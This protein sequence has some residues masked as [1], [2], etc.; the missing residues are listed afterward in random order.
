MVSE[1]IDLIATTTLVAS[2]AIGAV[3]LLRRSLHRL[4][5]PRVVYASWLLVPIALL[6]L[7]LPARTVSVE[8]PVF[9]RARPPAAIAMAGATSL[10]AVPAPAAA[11]GERDVRVLVLAVWLIG[12]ALATGLFGRQQWRFRRRIGRLRPRDDGS[13]ASATRLLGPAVLGLLRP[14]IIVPLDFDHRYDAEQRA[15]IL[16]HEAVHRRRGDL[17]ANAAATALRCIHWF[18]PLVHIAAVRFRAD[19]EL[20]CDAA[21]LARFPESRRRYADAMLKTQLADLGLPVGCAW[22]SSHPMRERIAMLNNPPPGALRLVVG[23]AAL[24]ATTLGSA[25]AVWAAQPPVAES[26]QSRVADAPDA[27]TIDAPRAAASVGGDYRFVLAA[28]V[29]SRPPLHATLHADASRPFAVRLG[30]GEQEILAEFRFHPSGDGPA[31]VD[32]SF[33]Q[34]DQVIGADTV[35]VD[36]SGGVE[37]ALIDL[38]ANEVRVQVAHTALEPAP[39]PAER[40]KTIRFVA[41]EESRPMGPADFARRPIVRAAAESELAVAPRM[42]WSAEFRER[43]A[44]WATLTSDRVQVRVLLDGDGWPQEFNFSKP[45]IPAH[46]EFRHIMLGIVGAHIVPARDR[47]GEP[48]P[49]WVTVDFQAP[50]ETVAAGP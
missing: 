10:T 27:S 46:P 8:Q 13:F 6:A 37:L 45:R 19:Q 24:V 28:T 22:Q 4:A 50:P 29:G 42:E 48:V 23:A 31:R 35:E 36:G 18:N 38:D 33:I 34:R 43:Q 40:G 21:V 20:A 47:F 17:W 11:R 1:A 9:D 5:G 7:A 14:R 15:L 44:E 16:A 39:L 3:L 49:A 26:L 41:A 12:F 2:G 32:A 30:E 25:A